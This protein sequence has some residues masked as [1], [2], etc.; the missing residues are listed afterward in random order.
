MVPTIQE[1]QK[2]NLSLGSLAMVKGKEDGKAA[3]PS[4]VLPSRTLKGR[5][6]VSLDC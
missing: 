2:C 4:G 1:N 5:M 3:R 6:E